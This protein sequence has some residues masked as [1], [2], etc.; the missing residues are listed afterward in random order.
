MSKYTL[1]IYDRSRVNKEILKRVI[2]LF[3]I[4][5]K[6]T[7]FLEFIES[8][9]RYDD[10]LDELLNDPRNLK[11]DYIIEVQNN[12]A[13]PENI[14]KKLR[15]LGAGKKAYLIS[16]DN[17][18]DGSIGDLK[19]VIALAEFEG[20]VYCLDSNLGYYEGHENWRYI[21]RAV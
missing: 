19:E 21:L 20:F 11:R 12:E 5:E 18:I 14:V 7:R 1:N 9:K 6:Q 13:A 3:V 10:F 17:E 8:P 2:E 4:K 16:S 15:Q